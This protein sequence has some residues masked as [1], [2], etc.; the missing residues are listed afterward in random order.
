MNVFFGP[1]QDASGVNMVDCIRV[2]LKTKEAFGFPDD[3]DEYNGSS[4]A[5]SNNNVN[6][7]SSADGNGGL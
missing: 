4:A 2:F 7:S 3:V 6:N 1:S 5:A